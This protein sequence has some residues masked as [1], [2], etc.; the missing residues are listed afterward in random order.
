MRPHENYKNMNEVNHK[1]EYN[2]K[3]VEKYLKNLNQPKNTNIF[4]RNPIIIPDL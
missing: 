4:S 2:Y 3:S 1:Y